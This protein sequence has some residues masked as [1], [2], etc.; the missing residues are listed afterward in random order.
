[1]RCKLFQDFPKSQHRS[2]FAVYSGSLIL[3]KHAVSLQKIKKLHYW[4][5]MLLL[6]NSAFE[7]SS[8]TYLK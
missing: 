4:K 6:N 5:L 8:Y 3:V 7:N 2:S 1:M